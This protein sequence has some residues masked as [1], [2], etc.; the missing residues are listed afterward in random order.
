MATETITVDDSRVVIGLGRLELLLAQR[1]ELMQE[2]GNG[3]LVSIRRTFREEGS[4]AGS[5]AP[6]APSTVRRYGAKALGHKLLVLS[7]R[8]LNSISV[9]TYQDGVVIGTNLKYAAVHQFGS[10]DRQ[11]AI[12][13]PTKDQSEATVE[14][15]WHQRK[16]SA[17]LAKKGLKGP[18]YATL[19]LEGPAAE[20]GTHPV[21]RMKLLGPSNQVTRRIKRI[22]PRNLFSVKGH[23]RHQNIPPRPYLV[24]RPEDPERIRGQV[25]AFVLK[26]RAEAGLEGE[27]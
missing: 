15:G 18:G 21:K 5:W 3:Q 7:G 14:V 12:G 11:V 8:L 27:A 4:P 24:F 20:S 22:G 1:T 23:S 9:K 26:A 6:L 13:P 17:K 10:A 16:Q 2:I 25:Q 19:R